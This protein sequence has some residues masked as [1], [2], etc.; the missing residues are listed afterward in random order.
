MAAE[1]DLARALRRSIVERHLLVVMNREPDGAIWIEGY[2]AQDSLPDLFEQ[3]TR[4][5]VLAGQ[6]PT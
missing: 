5:F 6:E 3:L 4:Y 2:V 1:N